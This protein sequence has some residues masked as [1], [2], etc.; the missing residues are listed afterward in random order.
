M[1]TTV[2]PSTGTTVG[3]CADRDTSVCAVYIGKLGE[4]ICNGLGSINGILFGE[5]C[6]KSCKKC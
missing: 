5:Y 4:N 1:T 2:T 3:I 6:K